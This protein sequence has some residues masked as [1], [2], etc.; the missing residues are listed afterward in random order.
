[1]PQSITNRGTYIVNAISTF[2]HT[3]PPARWILAPSAL[4]PHGWVSSVVLISS[5]RT[6]VVL[7]VSAVI[8][9]AAVRPQ[10]RR[11]RRGTRRNAR[12]LRHLR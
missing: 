4:R 8:C 6:S 2:L 1:L 7:R 9:S 5:L 11:G 10:A 12:K 3:K